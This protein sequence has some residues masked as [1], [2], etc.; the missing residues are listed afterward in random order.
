MFQI[1]IKGNYFVWPDFAYIN[2][3][4]QWNRYAWIGFFVNREPTVQGL[5]ISF[6]IKHIII[7]N[8]QTRRRFHCGTICTKE[9][10]YCY[11]VNFL[12]EKLTLKI[13]ETDA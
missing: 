7:F 13:L 10:R 5:H 8:I 2:R 6:F 11:A 12:E 3:I 9:L 4:I 1:Q